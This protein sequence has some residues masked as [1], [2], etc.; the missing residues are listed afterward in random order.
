MWGIQAMA[1]MMPC[2][3]NMW[4]VLVADFGAKAQNSF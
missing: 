3:S 2:L 1:S 4:M